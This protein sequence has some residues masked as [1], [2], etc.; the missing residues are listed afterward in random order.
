MKIN[1]K[2]LKEFIKKFRM[3]GDEKI[4]E[5]KF[6]FDDNGLNILATSPTKSCQVCAQLKTKAFSLYENIGTMAVNDLSGVLNVIDKFKDIEITLNKKGNCL[7]IVGGNTKVDIELVSEQF[8]SSETIIQGLTWNNEFIIDSG[9]LKDI[10]EKAQLNKDSEIKV[11]SGDG[12]IKFSNSGKYK[13]D[14]TIEAPTCKIG[15]VSKYGEAF[16]NSVINLNGQ[17]KMFVSTDYPCKIVEELDNSIIQIICSPR[18]ENQ[19]E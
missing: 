16:I 5:T 2:V 15:S 4:E 11:T 7:T 19:D 3:D 1:A 18:V 14:T 17:L 6:V 10:I 12:A 13:F 8:L 9:Q